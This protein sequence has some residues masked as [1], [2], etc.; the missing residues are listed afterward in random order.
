MGFTDGTPI[1]LNL[2]ASFLTRSL[3]FFSSDS[4]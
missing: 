4:S 1:G 2:L 3:E